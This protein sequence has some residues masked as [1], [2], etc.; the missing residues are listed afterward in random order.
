MHPR[1]IGELGSPESIHLSR[2]RRLY[3]PDDY[4]TPYEKLSSLP[5][6]EQHLKPGITRQYLEGQAKRVSDTEAARQMQ[7]AKIALLSRTRG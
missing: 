4:R 1:G 7:K 6:W 3:R 5:D 2:S